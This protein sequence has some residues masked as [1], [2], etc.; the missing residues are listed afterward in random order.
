MTAPEGKTPFRANCGEC[1][2]KWVAAWLPMKILKAAEVLRTARCPLC[3]SGKV[4]VASPSED[5]AGDT[6]SSP[7]PAKAG[8]QAVGQKT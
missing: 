6:S 8:K 4:F 7:V 1:G 3:A 5:E 2:H